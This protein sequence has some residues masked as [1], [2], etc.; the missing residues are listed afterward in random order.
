MNYW[1]PK[2]KKKKTEAIYLLY[3]IDYLQNNRDDFER[4]YKSKT[5]N[6]ASLNV[7]TRN[8]IKMEMKNSIF[9]SL[10]KMF[11]RNLADR[12]ANT[13]VS[14]Q[15]VFYL[16][17]AFEEDISYHTDYDENIA[18][19]ERMISGYTELQNSFFRMLA[20]S[21]HESYE[22]V[23]KSFN[24]YSMAIKTGQGLQ[25]NCELSWLSDEEKEFIF[26]QMVTGNI[27]YMTSN[28]RNVT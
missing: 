14:I 16:I 22:D 6:N 9:L 2:R 8:A 3:S 7:D 24:T 1:E 12:I 26:E 10:S 5:G 19:Y 20:G 4:V 28:I 23:I 11:Y 13:E 21:D 27:S 17:N 18:V 25:R 15:D